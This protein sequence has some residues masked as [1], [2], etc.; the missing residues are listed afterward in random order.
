MEIIFVVNLA[1]FVLMIRKFFAKFRPRSSADGLILV[2]DIGTE[3]VKALIY[4]I[5][6]GHGFVIGYSK[7]R[8]KLGDMSAGAIANIA[9]VSSRCTEAI[10]LASRMA[11][12]QPEQVVI[13]IA[14]ELV[15]G[16]TTVISYSREN[17][18]ARIDLPE[19]RAIVQRV[20]ARAFDRVRRELARD[21]GHREIDIKL[22]N[23]VITDSQIDGQHATNPLG[24]QGSEVTL[25]VF[26]SFAPLVHFGAIQ[27]I[28]A[29]LELDLLTIATEPF[30]VS[31]VFANEDSSAIFIDVGGGTTDLVLVRGGA[32]LTM[33]MFAVGGRT[34]TKRLAQDLNVS[35]IEAERLKLEY[36]QNKLPSRKTNIIKKAFSGDVEV[37]LTGVQLA[38]AEISKNEKLPSKIFLCGGGGKLPE[39]KIALESSEWTHVLP[40]HRQPIV[41]FLV[42]DDFTNF[43]D[44][45]GMLRTIQDVTPLALANLG[46]E[47]AGEEKL[48]SSILRKAV[49]IIQ[50]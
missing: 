33:R 43:T 22:V 23:A 6:E 14:G 18:T 20:Q 19:L 34:F 10:R 11:G 3:F 32:E 15:R 16:A 5:E 24:F 50:S 37:W 17:P 1:P 42:P 49:K 36:S 26:N 28:A 4:R 8:Q 48:L 45:T 47:F 35:F 13:G 40:F 25:S 30:A 7:I 41:K 38:L 44:E 21:I 39:L 27:T 12:Q 29:E 31:R 9:G 2:L 46:I